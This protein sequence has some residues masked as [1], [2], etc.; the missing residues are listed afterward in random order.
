MS[1]SIHLQQMLLL[2]NQGCEDLDQ[3][4][5]AAALGHFRSALSAL[6][7]IIHGQRQNEKDTSTASF[8]GRHHLLQMPL[9]LIGGDIAPAAFT[10]S[11]FFIYSRAMRM[12]PGVQFSEDQT[13][14]C[15]VFTS[16]VVFNLALTLHLQGLENYCKNSL[17]KAHSLYSHAHQLIYSI[18]NHYCEQGRPTEN[19]AFDLFVMALLNN[20]ALIYVEC[21]EYGRAGS[22]F[23]SMSRY[24]RVS[25]FFHGQ[26]ASRRGEMVL[27]SVDNMLLNATFLKFNTV[28]AAAAA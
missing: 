7:G 19:A 2:N 13:E 1:T 12:T 28:S 17:Q 9:H 26:L 24:A 20:T 27:K 21:S 18:I 22:A 4:N 8:T 10:N 5:R 14:N 6:K 3:G 15:T 16:F 23:Q 25:S 11:Q